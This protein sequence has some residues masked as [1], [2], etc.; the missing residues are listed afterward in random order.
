MLLTERY[1]G[2]IQLVLSCFD[3]V[4]LTG[5]LPDFCH[6]EAAT[7]ELNLRGIR[8]F[9]FVAF[10]KELRERIR[11]NAERL[12]AENGLEIE[13]LRNAR[14]RKEQRIQEILRQRG[15]HP[16]LV[17]IFSAL[18]A[19]TTFEPW[20]NKQTHKTYLRPDS[21]KCIH[22]YFYFIDEEFGLC[23]LRVPT[24]APYRLQFYFNGHSWLA[25]QLEK[26]KIGFSHVDNVFLAIDKP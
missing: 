23:Y 10:A 12:A 3:R 15:A 21:G 5:T 1:A 16:G 20:H 19:C 22:Y 26:R 4:I 25:R 14:T 9:D 8:I 2:R 18:E 6:A 11:A 17:H 13:F 24:W 7:R